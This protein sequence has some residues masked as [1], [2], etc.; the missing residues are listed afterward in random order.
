MKYASLV[1]TPCTYYAINRQWYRL[2]AQGTQRFFFCAALI[3][4]YRVTPEGESFS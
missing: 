2:T 3:F 4:V 1:S